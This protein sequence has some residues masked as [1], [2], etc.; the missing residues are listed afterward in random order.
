MFITYCNY[1]KTA[2]F[3]MGQWWQIEPG[4]LNTL[5]LRQDGRRFS[6]TRF[7]NAFSWMKM[8]EFHLK[9]H[10]SLCLR[11]QL[12]IFQHWFRYWLGAVQ[13]TSHYLNQWWLVYWHIYASLGLNEL[14]VVYLMSIDSTAIHRSLDRDLD[15]FTAP[16]HRPNGRHFSA[17]H[18]GCAKGQSSE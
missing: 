15:S 2:W 14:T 13:A 4:R 5:R 3:M 11:F 16:L 8:Y 1:L 18:Y 17:C 12:T 6:Q 9:F 10:W 7:S